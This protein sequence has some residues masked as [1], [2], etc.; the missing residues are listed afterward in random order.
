MSKTDKGFCPVDSLS[1]QDLNDNTKTNQKHHRE[2]ER[3]HSMYSLIQLKTLVSCGRDSARSLPLRRGFLLIPL[4]LVCFAFLPQMQAVLPPQITPNDGVDADGCY[5]SFVTAEGCGV[6]GGPGSGGLGSSA[7]GWRA[8]FF[9]GGS[10]WN[11]GVGAGALAI[12]TGDENTAAGA[13]ALLINLGAGGNTAYGAF[14]L[15]QNQLGFG[16]TAVGD[17]ALFENDVDTLGLAN[18][19]TA[20]G[21]FSMN[22]NVDGAVNVAVG[23]GTLFFNQVDGNTAV[24]TDALGES[25][26]TGDNTAVGHLAL[27]FNDFFGD[28]L[29]IHNT[30]VGS[31]ALQNN[32][33]AR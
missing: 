3:T 6:L 27:N 32:T 17:Q 28:A 1:V 29:A 9:S 30:A 24:G 31:F 26:F 7:F 4:V 12:N 19:N 25:V 23:A 10:F 13:G 33:D 11:T 15:F 21:H 14:T 16:N 2:R 22:L 20:V 18:R 8:L 5:P